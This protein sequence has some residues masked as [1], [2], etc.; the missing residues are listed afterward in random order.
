MVRVISPRPPAVHT[1]QFC[2]YRGRAPD[3]RGRRRPLGHDRHPDLGRPRRGGTRGRPRLTF[4][5]RKSVHLGPIRRKAGSRAG[6][7]D[8]LRA[9]GASGCARETPI[10]RVLDAVHNR[11][12]PV[13]P[14]RRGLRVYRPLQDSSQAGPRRR[15]VDSGR[16]RDAGRRGRGRRQ[17]LFDAGFPRVD[18]GGRGL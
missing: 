11:G 17:D 12:L 16:D 18:S 10:S 5:P 15:G 9:E 14:I 1:L 13:M 2:P 6:G 3:V 7:G 8:H 4:Q